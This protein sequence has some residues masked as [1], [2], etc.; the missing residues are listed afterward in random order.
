VVLYVCLSRD[1]QRPSPTFRAVE[2]YGG[3]WP[4]RGEDTAPYISRRGVIRV[5]IT[6][7]PVC[8]PYIIPLRWRGAD[9]VGGVVVGAN[10]V[11]PWHSSND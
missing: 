11:R 4:R 9:A 1:V 6:G 5:F 8:V 3:V 2:Y 7:R 10:S